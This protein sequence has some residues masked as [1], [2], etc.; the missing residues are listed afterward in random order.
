MIGTPGFKGQRLTQ[1]REARGL[2]AVALAEMIGV[3]SANI[4]HYEHGK[5]TPSPEVMDRI[6]QV[7]NC[8][9]A[10]FLR[11]LRTKDGSCIWYRSMSAATKMSRVRAEA[12]LAW[13]KEI[14]DYLREYL[15]LP[16]L[17]MPAFD[18]P[19]DVTKITSAMIED[20]ATQCRQFW[21]LGD[22]PISDLVLALEN[23][24]VIVGRG[25]LATET[26]DSFSQWPTEENPF[27]YLNSDKASAVRLR[28]DA[29]HEL[30]H[31]LLHRHL[32]N[33]QFKTSTIN[34]LMENQCH[35]FGIALLLPA[36][37][38][39]TELWAPTLDGFYTLKE[40]WGVSIAAMIKRCEQL[41][42]LDEERT[43]RAWINLSRRGWKKWEPLDDTLVPEL[44]RVL[45]R[46]V[47]ILSNAGIKT[48]S[49]MLVDLA[50][51]ASDFEDL[52]CLPSGY[53]KGNAVG[54]PKIRA[55]RVD[56]MKQEG[57]LMTFQK[58]QPN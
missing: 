30:G 5:Q 9:R 37:R 55:L 40:R 29:A 36:N 27:V 20:I 57:K 21:N 39:S 32:D 19:A 23:N 49:Q 3:K 11:E 6:A 4:S 44:P 16:K 18:L 12:R 22:G 7:L 51:S 45:P 42:I 1:A 26:Q 56:E 10:F 50:M 35:R 38:F 47:E 25:E 28:F 24:G 58:R 48:P 41:E 52:C 8:P 14:V 53:T 13:L 15:E 33:K 43:L 54:I 2:T 34:R 46:G 31:L 17:N